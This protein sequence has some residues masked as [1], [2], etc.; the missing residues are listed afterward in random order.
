M[1]L[2][3]LQVTLLQCKTP[4]KVCGRRSNGFPPHYTPA[5]IHQ[6]RFRHFLDTR[7]QSCVLHCN[8]T[9]DLW[10]WSKKKGPTSLWRIREQQ[11]NT[12]S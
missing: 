11:L 3:A 2:Q 8:K 4:K 7:N 5:L 6:K 1:L 12:I 9:M 10:S